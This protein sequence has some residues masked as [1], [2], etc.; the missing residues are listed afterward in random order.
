MS[1]YD[2]I[3]GNASETINYQ[4]AVDE[5][6]YPNS[7]NIS[8]LG[9]VWAPR[10]YGK[11]LTAFEI[12][13]SGK[14]AIAISDVHALDFLRTT[15]LGRSKNTIRA[16]SNDVLELY[17]DSNEMSF[18]MDT[19]SNLINVRSTAAD[20]GVDVFAKSN[21]NITAELGEMRLFTSNNAYLRADSNLTLSA[22]NSMFVRSEQDMT[23]I[24]DTSNVEIVASQQMLLQ[25][26][27]KEMFIK[28][29]SNLIDVFAASNYTLTAGDKVYVQAAS[30]ITQSNTADSYHV[31]SQSNIL[32]V[33]TTGRM[34]FTTSG[35]DDIFLTSGCNVQV[36]TQSNMVLSNLG[37]DLNVSSFSNVTVEAKKGD[38]TVSA[39]SNDFR[40]FAYSN[41]EM[42]AC[43]NTTIFTLCNM[44]LSNNSNLSIYSKNDV[45][46]V[47]DLGQMD[48]FAN[49]GSL[50][51]FG[52]NAT[53]F[54]TSNTLTVES[55]GS[56]TMCNK[57]TNF[58]LVSAVD[59]T[60]VAETGKFYI[61][62]NNE[63]M[64]LYSASNVTVDASNSMEL[65]AKSNITVS[66]LFGDMKLSSFSNMTL[67]AEKKDM[68]LTAYSNDMFINTSNVLTISTSNR[69]VANTQ[70][71]VT[72]CNFSSDFTIS[73][74][75]N[76]YGEALK[77]DISF[78]SV[79]ND[80]KHIAGSNI[81]I[82][83]SNVMTVESRSNISF[84]NVTGDFKVL[85]A[86]NVSVVGTAGNVR[87]EATGNTMDIVSRSN[88][89]VATSNTLNI[90]AS[91]IVGF[92][93]SNITL[94]SQVST[95]ISA[96]NN[97]A[98]TACNNGSLIVTNQL[99]ISGKPIAITSAADI[100]VTAQSNVNFYIDASPDTPADPVVTVAGNLLKVRGDIIISGTI[101]TSNILQT[102]IVQETLK[103]S[104]KTILV[105]SVGDG[106]NLDYTPEDSFDN[107]NASGIRVD[108]YPNG[109]NPLLPQ[110][111]YAKA[112]LWKYA[113]NSSVSAATGGFN[114]L[115]GSM[116]ASAS[117]ESYW[118]ILGGGLRI[119]HKKISG[120]S[121]KDL[122]FGFRVNDKDELELYK[123]YWDTTA[124]PPAYKIKRVCRFGR[125][126]PL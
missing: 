20:G 46:V 14:I 105:A 81:D 74:D 123:R 30:N 126:L 37:G 107:N 112:L 31:S 26:E 100:S 102:T 24:S 15:Y 45:D 58:T 119:T 43:N 33:A 84:T 98:M 121:Y 35:A 78:V 51:I 110:D 116:E 101:N 23:L 19:H 41:I 117:N 50:N 72:F 27:T 79:L 34:S 39:Y 71:N 64:Y 21:M 65:S 115:G 7:N 61:Q 60:M 17:A 11:D 32:M 89:S 106:S 25:S 10:I 63:E 118:E 36:V 57:T 83:A 99:N 44:T 68:V 3:T 80:I 5:N 114:A 66:N 75:S 54:S 62:A 29:S 1:V 13:S 94:T 4:P 48:I 8:I 6:L 82:S 88:M 55:F 73:S 85:S 56:M 108:G 90:E 104:D 52:S 125:I 16:M 124:V 9:S 18:V 76:I 12:A 87:V 38:I 93:T 109:Y 69:W 95:F 28:S 113:D 92:A 67:I 120:N 22:S 91:N 40:L 96:S 47:S 103:V 77:G 122:S 111:V 53:T 49:T 97:L 70:S 86:S 2:S 59:A 42:T